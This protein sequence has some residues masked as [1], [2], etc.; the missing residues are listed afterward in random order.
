[1]DFLK[2]VGGKIATGVVVLA[3]GVAG[4]AW[5]ETAP[6][7]KHAVLTDSGRII[8]WTL[9]VLIL[10]WASFAL[11]GWV[12]KFDTNAAGAALVFG[13][14]AVQAVILAWLFGWSVHGATL[15]T[16]YA[17]AVLI[18]GVYN[19]FACDWIAERVS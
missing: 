15:W 18:A 2:T 1:M 14:T 17:A 5:Y 9:L 11:V 4:L 19:L 8:G 16:V 12:A 6:E 10:P 7:T 3:V 13:M